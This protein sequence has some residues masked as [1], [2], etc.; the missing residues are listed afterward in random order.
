[1]NNAP[2]SYQAPLNRKLQLTFGPV[3]LGLLF[4]TLLVV[5]ASSYRSIGVAQESDHWV[6]HTY[7]V[8]QNLQELLS[9]V[10]SVEF[11]YRRFVDTGDERFLASYRE[12]ILRSV[13]DD[14]IIRYLTAD[15]P[16]QQRQIPTLERLIGQKIQFA[17]R[18]IALRRT[19]GIAAAADSIGDGQGQENMAEFQAELRVM[20]DEELRLLV[21]RNADAQSRLTQSKTALILGIGLGLLLVAAASWSVQ[22]DSSRRSLAEDALFRSEEHTSE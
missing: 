12:G 14:T 10:Q 22:R 13:H 6:R 17:E 1:M 5:G 19:K 9:E 18:V 16:V 20:Q 11:S 4:L 15:N 3:I 21:V 2:S 7:E 8:L